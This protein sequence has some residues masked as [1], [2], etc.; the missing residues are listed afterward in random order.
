[1]KTIYEHH[2]EMA[3]VM[4][5]ATK[6]EIKKLFKKLEYAKIQKTKD[7]ELFCYIRFNKLCKTFVKLQ[8]LLTHTNWKWQIEEIQAVVNGRNITYKCIFIVNLEMEYFDKLL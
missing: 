8:E 1:M 7:G 3:K 5:I 6:K 4:M 2:I